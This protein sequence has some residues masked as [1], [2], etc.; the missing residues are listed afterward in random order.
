M[1]SESE[2]EDV[3]GV[4]GTMRWKE[5]A[6]PPPLPKLL[7]KQDVC[8][9]SSSPHNRVFIKGKRNFKTRKGKQKKVGN[10]FYSLFAG[11][12]SPRY[13]FGYG[14][15]HTCAGIQVKHN[16]CLGRASFFPP[17]QKKLISLHAWH[18]CIRV[19]CTGHA[20]VSNT[21]KGQSKGS[22]GIR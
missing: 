21:F 14:G 6:L 22:L 17:T 16:F 10:L 2:R 15:M 9:A 19:H 5:Q 4:G 3:V 18:T 20:W 1:I 12:S 13:S 11:M 7:P 8:T